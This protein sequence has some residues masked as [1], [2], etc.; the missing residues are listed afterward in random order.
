MWYD[1]VMKIFGQDHNHI[2]CLCIGSGPNKTTDISNIIQFAKTQPNKVII[3]T[4]QSAHI[5]TDI[6][7]SKIIDVDL[8]IHDEMHHL[9]TDDKCDYI[10]NKA[11]L[12]LPV[13]KI[14]SL[15][16]TIKKTSDGSIV[17]KDYFSDVMSH[18][19]DNIDHYDLAFAIE[20][21]YVCDYN[22]A[23]LDMVNFDKTN[24][25]ITDQL[26]T[27]LQHAVIAMFLAIERNLCSHV[28][29][30]CNTTDDARKIDKLIANQHL[31]HITNNVDTSTDVF[32]NIYTSIV[33]SDEP[34]LN[35]PLIMKRFRDSPIGIITCVYMLGE[36]FNEPSIDGCVFV[37][38]MT[39]EIRI[40]QSAMRCCRIDKKRPN[41]RGLLLVPT[42]LRYEG[43]D[44]N[45]LLTFLIKQL[46]EY[47]AVAYKRI[48]MWKIGRD[49]QSHNEINNDKM[50]LN[51][52]PEYIDNLVLRI[53]NRK[54]SIRDIYNRAREI[55]ISN[56]IDSITKFKLSRQHIQAN[57]YDDP[58]TYFSK[59]WKCWYDFL[60]VD[61]SMMITDIEELKKFI[62]AHHINRDNYQTMV[63]KYNCLP[64][65]IGC[66]YDNAD[67]GKIFPKIMRR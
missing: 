29:V 53:I 8:I 13:S 48:S 23:V 14:I 31:H 38:N 24:T 44:N 45:K 22:I 26:Y 46:S 57:Y 34:D 16:A 66:L 18:I 37:S 28:L 58:K 32:D 12:N 52:E 6:N 55:N 42:I 25:I 3:T 1:E 56:N 62:A 50:I 5:L 35:I 10:N 30:Y 40:V 65:E 17:G 9:Q 59:V 4:T 67:Y 43:D 61:Y 19:H 54:P 47:D 49:I 39:S 33:V 36:G 15:S 64:P 41:K 2:S 20:N 63:K 51:N 7:I 21:G 11:I 27:P 60:G